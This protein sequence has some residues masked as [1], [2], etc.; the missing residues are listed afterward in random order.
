MDVHVGEQ[1]G[2]RVSKVNIF[3]DKGMNGRYD[4]STLDNIIKVGTQDNFRIS[5]LMNLIGKGKNKKGRK[6]RKHKR[7]RKQKNH[8]V[9]ETTST[10]STDYETAE[11]PTEELPEIDLDDFERDTKGSKKGNRRPTS[12]K[13]GKSEKGK[14]R[15]STGRK[16]A[17][18]RK[19]ENC[20]SS[21]SPGAEGDREQKVDDRM[22]QAR[23]G[24]KE[25]ADQSPKIKGQMEVDDRMTQARKGTKG[26][27]DQSPKIKGQMQE[28]DDRMNQARKGTKGPVD[29]SPKIKGQMQEVDD[30]MT[31]ARKG[32]KGP[33]DQS[34]KIKGQT[35]EVDDRMT[36]ARKGTKGPVDQS[37]KIKGQTI[38]DNNRKIKASRTGSRRTNGHHGLKSKM[39]RIK[40]L[41]NSNM[42]MPSDNGDSGSSFMG[43]LSNGFGKV[44]STLGNFATTAGETISNKI[45]M[46]GKWA[47]VGTEVLGGV[48]RG[49]NRGLSN[50]AIDDSNDP[51]RSNQN[52]GEEDDGVV[53]IQNPLPNE[54]ENEDTGTDD[55]APD[56]IEKDKTD[57]VD[58]NDGDAAAAD[59]DPKESPIPHQENGNDGNKINGTEATSENEHLPVPESTKATINADELPT[60]GDT[61]EKTEAEQTP[62]A[63]DPEATA[64]EEQS[65]NIES[66]EAPT[67][68]EQLLQVGN[69][70]E[71]TAGEEQLPNVEN[72]EEA[73]AGEEQL[74]KEKVQETVES[75]EE[76]FK[77][78]QAIYLKYYS[79]NNEYDF[80]NKVTQGTTSRYCMK[81]HGMEDLYTIPPTCCSRRYEC[82]FSI[83]YNQTKIRP[84]R[85]WSTN[86]LRDC[87]CDKAFFKCL[88]STPSPRLIHP[89][90]LFVHDKC[91]IKKLNRLNSTEEIGYK[92]VNSASFFLYP[93]YS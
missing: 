43:G 45:K 42:E 83:E 75:L 64:G 30:R 34:P 18:C 84:E 54:M 10:F 20:P 49:I 26:P 32:T 46:T 37:P 40:S 2:V 52:G 87:R 81:Q 69:T 11:Q 55:V 66:N 14:G 86:R 80:N 17:S 38:K 44:A 67:E 39:R 76:I 19:N 51:G 48:A 73:T 35:Q 7:P 33:V 63:D 74:S 23:K 6:H 15:D 82:E 56:D 85:K 22:N 24:T 21:R 71:A 70:E 89:I 27:A 78:E 88:I 58:A 79:T 68:E 4:A 57:D 29:Q 28:V 62:N 72:T 53:P 50:A 41:A 12:S 36:Q 1:D 93:L 8:P 13:E 90:L 9:S 92:L 5:A 65:P 47:D 59:I 25:P 60:V 31:Q 61:E 3:I 91:S 16:T 77:R